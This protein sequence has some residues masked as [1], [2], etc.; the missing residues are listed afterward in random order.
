LVIEQNLFISNYLWKEFWIS[1]KHLL[2]VLLLLTQHM[3]Y[4]FGG[5]QFMLRLSLKIVW[6]DPNQTPR[7][8][9]ASWTVIFLQRQVP[10]LKPYFNLLRWLINVSNVQDVQQT[11]N[12]IQIWKITQTNCILPIIYFP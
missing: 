3:R 10:S 7:I 12:H 2:K 4:E 11:S 6:T 5:N 8:L 9:A 1:L